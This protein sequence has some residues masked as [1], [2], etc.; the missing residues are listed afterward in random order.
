M[1]TQTS[2][3]IN[4]IRA[5]IGFSAKFMN[6]VFHSYSYCGYEANHPYLI[7]T[8]DPVTELT[9]AIHNELIYVL[10]QIISILRVASTDEDSHH[11]Q[12]CRW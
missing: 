10:W 5:N 2:V 7:F 3:I 6:L 9:A 12:S 8:E 4:F 11:S 1:E